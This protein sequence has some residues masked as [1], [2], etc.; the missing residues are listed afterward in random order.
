MLGEDFELTS[1]APLAASAPVRRVRSL[2]PDEDRRLMAAVA[3][4][5]SYRIYHGFLIREGM[6]ADEAGRLEPSDLDLERGAVVLDENKTDDPRA[7]ALSPDVV[8]ALRTYLA[9]SLTRAPTRAA[10]P[11]SG[12]RPRPPHSRPP[13]RAARGPSRTRTGA[14]S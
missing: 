11:R 6:R 2:Y 9:G 5:L 3:I 7:W 10:R 14:G 13:R 12:T 4:P 8:R 1:A